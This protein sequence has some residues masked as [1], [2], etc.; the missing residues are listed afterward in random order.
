MATIHGKGGMVYLQG[1]GNAAT[2]LGEARSWKIAIDSETDEDNAL[3]DTWKT[4]L[5][6]LMGWNMSV[7]GNF[8]TAETSPFDAATASTV[9]TVYLYPVAASTA[10]YYYGSC[11]PKLNV[12]AGLGGTARFTLDAD[13][14]G[15][16]SLN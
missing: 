1:S 16:I 11:W 4:S 7:E 6:G 13:G 12:E 15:A 8:D 9:K 10:R 5:K 14:S 2:M 3:G